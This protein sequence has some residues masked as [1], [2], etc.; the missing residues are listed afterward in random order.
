MAGMMG[1]RAALVMVSSRE[2]EGHNGKPALDGAARG[3]TRRR[4]DV[5]FP[6]WT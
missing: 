3:V 5:T 4:P 2:E 6:L 1:Q